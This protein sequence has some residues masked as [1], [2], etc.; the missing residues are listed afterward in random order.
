M[1]GRFSNLD[2]NSKA[3]SA[4][5]S[6]DSVLMYR[7]FC[8]KTDSCWQ[9]FHPKKG[10]KIISHLSGLKS[11]LDW[12][13]RLNVSQLMLPVSDKSAR[14]SQT[15]KGC[16]RKA[17]NSTFSEASVVIERSLIGTGYVKVSIPPDQAFQFKNVSLA[18]RFLSAQ[19][20]NL[21]VIYCSSCFQ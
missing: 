9:I 7:Q 14:K 20:S 13:V 17:I 19:R 8:L 6:V 2:L 18:R 21:I 3:I 4:L 1:I 16:I 12:N 10:N 5:D 11:V 15:E